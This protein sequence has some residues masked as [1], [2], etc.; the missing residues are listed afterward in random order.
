MNLMTTGKTLLPRG[1]ALASKYDP[2]T[3][4]GTASRSDSRPNQ[5]PLLPRQVYSS[6]GQR[7]IRPAI[8]DFS[9]AQHNHQNDAGGGLLTR[10]AMQLVVKQ[11]PLH[12]SGGGY[13]NV[14]NIQALPDGVDSNDVECGVVPDDYASG[15]ITLCYLFRPQ[16]AGTAI[17]RR[18]VYV[19]RDGVSIITIDNNFNMD[20]IFPT[21]A[22]TRLESTIPAADIQAGDVIRCDVTRLGTAGLDT[23][24]G[25]LDLDMMWMEYLGYP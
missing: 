13:L 5:G 20:Y 19:L 23:I 11:A 6:A 17:L 22:V 25:V 1:R 8:S 9:L 7:F 24:G 18:Y 21:D 10:E 3:N 12:I 2:L 15:D 4:Y 14:Y 16:F